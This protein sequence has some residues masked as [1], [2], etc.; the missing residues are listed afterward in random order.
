[1][2]ASDQKINARESINATLANWRTSPMSKWAFHHVRELIPSAEIRNNPEAI[3]KLKTCEKPLKNSSMDSLLNETST[4]A[5]VIIHDN[6]I[7]FETYRNGMQ[8]EDPHILFSVSKSILGLIAGCLIRD[9]VFDEADLIT[10]YLPEMIGTA[11]YSAT[12]RDA[13]DMQVGVYF[14]EDYDAKDGPIIDYRYAANWNPTPEAKI[15]MTLKSFLTSL[16]QQD[17]PHGGK[18]HYVSP[19]TDLLAWL[20]ERASGKRY[21]DLIA[22]YIW[23]PI[24]SEHSAYITVD[25]IGGMRAAGGICMT[26]RDL[27]RLGALVSQNGVRSFRQIVPSQ[28]ITDLHTVRNRKAWDEGTFKDFFKSSAMHYRSQWYVCK[29]LGCLL[30]GFGIH[31]Q[32]LFVDQDRKLS[33]AWL[34]SERDPLNKSVT[35]KIFNV[36]N[37]IRQSVGLSEI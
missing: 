10:D 23:K 26:P 29:K 4:D 16:E 20:F 17:G 21:A 27:G 19:N 7:I 5:V 33:I 37:E 1:M 35:Q 15:A 25:R 3:W 28:W 8:P 36:V 11:Y 30:Y 32:Y 31:G 34:S 2:S 18:F 12:I 13:L 9:K 14:D 6:C 24:G 22:D